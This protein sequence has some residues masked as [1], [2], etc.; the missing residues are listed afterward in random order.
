MATYFF[1]VDGTLLRYHK[2]EWISGAKEMLKKL[3]LAG[4]LIILITMRG[5]QD[6]NTLWSVENTKVFFEKENIKYPVF[7]GVQSPRIIVDDFKPYAI[8][9][10]RDAIWD[11]NKIDSINQ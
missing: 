1:D 10:K 3:E 9:V 8:N 4:N 7:Y 2:N 6:A 11:A 5:T